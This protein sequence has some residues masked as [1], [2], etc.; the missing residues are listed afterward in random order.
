MDLAVEAGFTLEKSES[1]NH[2]TKEHKLDA[3]IRC[4][5]ARIV[6]R[7]ELK[8]LRLLMRKLDINNEDVGRDEH[9]QHSDTGSS[10]T[11]S[12]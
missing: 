3:I 10:A 1:K 11:N 4:L 7:Q 12:S 9:G 6:D 5:Q 2:P 8:S